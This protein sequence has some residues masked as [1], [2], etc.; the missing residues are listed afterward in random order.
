MSDELI[1]KATEALTGV[2]GSQR[3]IRA[4]FDALIKNAKD[5]EE[6]L[7]KLEGQTA[8]T[9]TPPTPTPPTPTPPTPSG[10]PAKPTRVVGPMS[11]ASGAVIENVIIDG[12]GGG[13]GIMISSGVKGVKVRNVEV[14]N[15][16]LGVNMHP[17]HQ[18]GHLFQFVDVHHTGDSGWMDQAHAGSRFEDCTGNFC[19]RDENGNDLAPKFGVDPSL[20][21][22]GWYM[23][24]Q[25]QFVRCGARGNKKNGFSCRTSG[26]TLTDCHGGGQAITVAFF[27]YAGSLGAA[28]YPPVVIERFTAEIRGGQHFFYGDGSGP[29]DFVIKDCKLTAVGQGAGGIRTDHACQSTNNQFLT[30][31]NGTWAYKEDI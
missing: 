27:D 28:P 13:T 23:K 4:T 7:D 17:Q 9:P 18:G 22:H 11:P 2:S 1:D 31:G 25:S 26:M 5:Q 16:R 24:S 21:V 19:G 20:G 3:A 10:R 30:T 12:N 8:P 14:R 6:R 15:C 29:P